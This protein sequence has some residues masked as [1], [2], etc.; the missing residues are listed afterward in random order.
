MNTLQQNPISVSLLLIKVT[1]SQSIFHERVL[2]QVCK[3]TY[4]MLKVSWQ[5]A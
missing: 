2:S 3:F 5:I 4:M 1:V